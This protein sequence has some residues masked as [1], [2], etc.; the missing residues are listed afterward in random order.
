MPRLSAIFACFSAAVWLAAPSV[1]LAC[2]YCVTQNKDAGMTGVMLLGA[3]IA[4]PFLIFFAVVPAIKRAAAED[5]HLF[6]SDSE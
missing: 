1:A 2:P 5:A 4:L 6:P 3:M